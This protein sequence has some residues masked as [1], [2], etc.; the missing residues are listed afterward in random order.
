MSSD[1]GV[2][3]CTQNARFQGATCLCPE[4]G[5]VEVDERMGSSPFETRATQK[6]VGLKELLGESEALMSVGRVGRVPEGVR[7]L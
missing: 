6:E 7:A 5:V 4:G 3:I 1:T 2:V